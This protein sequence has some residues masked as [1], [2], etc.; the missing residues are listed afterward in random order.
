M[1][2]QT[3]K[4]EHAT[5]ESILETGKMTKE[6]RDDVIPRGVSDDPNPGAIQPTPL[7]D[8]LLQNAGDDL[9]D[10]PKQYE[11]PRLAMAKSQD[12]RRLA[13]AS[14]WEGAEGIPETLTRA[15]DDDPSGGEQQKEIPQGAAQK[16]VPSDS[17]QGR[18]NTLALKVNGLPMEV[19]R[20]TALQHAEID[21][22]DADLFT[23]L[24]IIKIAQTKLAAESFLQE[25]KAA[26]NS[27]R[28]A[29]A[30]GSTP[31][32]QQADQQ[33]DGTQ[34]QPAQHQRPTREQVIE[35]L[36]FE[37][38]EVAGEVLDSYIRDSIQQTL[39]ESRQ[40]SAI[41]EVRG[42]VLGTLQRIET[43]HADIAAHEHAR[44]YAAQALIDET[45]ADLRRIPGMQEGVIQRL[46]ASG[47]LT[48]AYVRARHDGYNVRPPEDIATAA[49]TRTRDL[50]RMPAPQREQAPQQ[51]QQNGIAQRLDAK[52]NLINQPQGSSGSTG[53]VRP[54]ATDID[55]HRKAAIDNRRAAYRR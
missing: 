5:V 38:P 53:N 25:A 27:A 44:G 54:T 21:P 20:E 49:I 12:A 15:G 45:A 42:S 47:N 17:G 11:D 35:T 37:S 19:T 52:R 14:E 16:A 50:Y 31:E 48:E 1:T 13:E 3:M 39:T 33:Q 46:I 23:D 7:P 41:D 26:R 6:P 43:E 2:T 30:A 18:N 36:Q 40:V 32:H 24:Q 22:A 10:M 28:A 9:P 51:Q 4:S 29:S 8:L 34:N 55:S